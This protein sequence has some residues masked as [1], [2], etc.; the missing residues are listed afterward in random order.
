MKWYVDFYKNGVKQSC[1]FEDDEK[2]ASDIKI[3]S[4][5]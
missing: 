1:C 3:I 4:Q 5:I 2:Q